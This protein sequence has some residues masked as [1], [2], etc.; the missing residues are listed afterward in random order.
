MIVGCSPSGPLADREN[1]LPA[2]QAGELLPRST[3]VRSCPEANFDLTSLIN[4]DL[5]NWMLNLEARQLS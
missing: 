5:A 1:L 4:L 3:Q 2:T